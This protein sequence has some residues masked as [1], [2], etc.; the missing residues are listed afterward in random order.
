[1][2]GINNSDFGRLDVQVF[3]INSDQ[4]DDRVSIRHGP[5]RSA[6]I[7]ILL[8]EARIIGPDLGFVN[9]GDHVV[10]RTADW[11]VV[12]RGSVSGDSAGLTRVFE[13]LRAPLER[14]DLHGSVGAARR[15]C[16]LE[17][18][19]RGAAESIEYVADIAPLL[20]EKCVP[21][22]RSGGIGPFAMDRWE[23]VYGFA[24]MMR[25]VVRTRRM[26]PWHADSEYGV[27]SNDRSLTVGETKMLVQ[28]IESGASRGAGGQDPLAQPRP[29]QALWTLGRPDIVLKIPPFEVPESGLV[30]YR[31]HEMPNPFGSDVWVRATEY[32]PGDPAA[33]HHALVSTGA[34]YFGANLGGYAPGHKA[35]ECP[36]D[37]GVLVRADD[38]LS[39]QIH[40]TPYGRRSIDR[41]RLGIHLHE[42][43]PLHRLRVGV[44]LNTSIDIPANDEWHRDSASRVFHRPIVLYSVLPHMHYRGKAAEVRA[45]YR[46]GQEEVLLSVPDYDFNWQTN[47]VFEKP[48]F[49]P[50]GTTVVQTS[51]WDNSARNLGNPNPVRAVRWGFQSWDEM[52]AAWITFRYAD[53]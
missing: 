38:Y 20:I 36:D 32:V 31:Y 23:V 11:R 5:R 53:E 42:K 18:P 22:H 26:P 27:F 29:R 46:D 17:T 45:I 48:K 8:D 47:Y 9:G 10:V 7:P 34:T 41:S 52:L 30:E 40:Y 3:G 49:L 33:V 43:R 13:R 35:M 24:P 21:C 51:W 37:T 50:A 28:W 39:V 2:R 14:G 16:P 4:S 44:V 15:P 25:E 6:D 12:F 19:P 1:M